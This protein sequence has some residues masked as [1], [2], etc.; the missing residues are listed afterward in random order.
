M[1]CAGLDPGRRNAGSSSV[2]PLG[3]Q[4]RCKGPERAHLSRLC[5]RS[6]AGPRCARPGRRSRQAIGIKTLKGRIVAVR[7]GRARFARHP[8][9][10]RSCLD[11]RGGKCRY[12][13]TYDRQAIPAGSAEQRN[14]PLQLRA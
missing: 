8:N 13:P 1:V 7:Q 6:A 2:L 4:A 9:A 10:R 14:C 11:R 3:A 12:L 5:R